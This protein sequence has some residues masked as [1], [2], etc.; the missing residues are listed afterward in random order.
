MPHHQVRQPRVWLRDREPRYVGRHVAVRQP[1]RTQRPP[2]R[3][4]LAVRLAATLTASSFIVES[5]RGSSSSPSAD[6][7]AAS[8][9]SGPALTKPAVRRSCGVKEQCATIAV[10]LDYSRPT[11]R[12]ITIAI[13]RFVRSD[14]PAAVAW[15]AAGEPG[16]AGDSGITLTRAVRVGEGGRAA[17]SDLSAAAR[18]GDGHGSCLRAYKQ[19]T[20]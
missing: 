17:V 1:P 4:V 10:P 12:R 2:T 6:A 19:L 16:R 20:S 18:H 14:W 7:A 13:D 8:P 5:H 3:V 15:R 11:G 9:P